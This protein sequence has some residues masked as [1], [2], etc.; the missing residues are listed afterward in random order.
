MSAS[1]DGRRN[2][3]REK[4]ILSIFV[5]AVGDVLLTG[6]GLA[7]GLVEEVN[8]I[9]VW[10]FDN[11]G[12]VPGLI[13]ALWINAV[14]ILGLSLAARARPWV[15]PCLWGLLVVRAAVFI[16]HIHWLAME[17]YF[18]RLVGS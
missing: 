1:Q 13:G 7:G 9:A 8:P 17:G 3:I 18:S 11:L 16:P 5:A 12:L 14:C 10:V 4:V 2:N 15:M 6:Y